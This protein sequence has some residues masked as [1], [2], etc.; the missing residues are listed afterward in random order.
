MRYDGRIAGIVIM[1]LISLYY[2]LHHVFEDG[3]IYYIDLPFQ[4]GEASGDSR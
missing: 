4:F 1:L 2:I 3:Q